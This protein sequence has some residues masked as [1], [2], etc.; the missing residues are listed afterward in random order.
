MESQSSQ[1]R[2]DRLQL[3][4]ECNRARHAAETADQRELRLLQQRECL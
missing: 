2:D 1:D 4:K 3:R